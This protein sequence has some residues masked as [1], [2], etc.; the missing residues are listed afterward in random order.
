MPVLP[1]PFGG[2]GK[3]EEAKK[4]PPTLEPPALEPP[5]LDLPLKFPQ[6][7]LPPEALIA[8][9]FVLG[10]ATAIATGTVYKRFFKRIPN[11][12]WI[13]PD[14]LARRRWIKGTVTSVGDADNFRLYHTPGIGWRWPFKFRRVPTASRDLRS[15]TIH[16]RIAG[17]DAPE[18]AHFGRPA[19]PFADE[20]LEWLRSQVGGKQIYCRLLRRDQYNRVV[21]IPLLPP[22]FLPSALVSGQPL[23]LAMLRAG[24]VQVYEQAGAE[25]GPWGKEEF[26]RLQSEAQA[27]RRGIWVKG[28]NFE[29]PAEYKR[30]YARGGSD[31][32]MDA[33]IP[34]EPEKEEKPGVLRRLVRWAIG[35]K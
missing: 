3:K 24:W 17:V 31:A 11:S 10:G 20:A 8:V 34:L 18:G 14:I 22:R 32:D 33:E 30:R 1:W 7:D 5:A 12:E 16:I 13:T 21:A 4:E 25:Y 28:T 15:Q 19:Q 26:L 35:S 29:S 27:A 9:A 23:A 6:T 2:G